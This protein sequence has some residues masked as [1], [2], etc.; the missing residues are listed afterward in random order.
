MKKIDINKWDRAEHFNFFKTL[1][2]PNYSVCAN[3]DVTGIT[4]IKKSIPSAPRLSD[5]IYYCAARAANT[6]DEMRMRIVEG[7]PVLFENINLGFTYIPQGRT[8]HANCVAEYNDDFEVTRKAIEKAR[9]DADKNPTLKPEGGA[10][11][12]FFYFSIL[13]GISFTSACNPWGNP[14]RD[15]IP[16]ILFGEIF[17]ENGHKKMPVSVEVLHCFVDGQHLAYFFDGMNKLCSTPQKYFNL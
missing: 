15:S 6:I 2:H 16:R 9:L 4:E 3:V 10:G 12:N 11:Q 17:E 1:D 7:G 8:L 5:L 13:P 14:K